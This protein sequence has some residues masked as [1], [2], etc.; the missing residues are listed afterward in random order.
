MA[1]KLP[2]KDLPFKF[3]A[4]RS[5]KPQ[6]DTVAEACSSAG[7]LLASAARSLEQVRIETPDTQAPLKVIYI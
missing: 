7:N 6:I 5:L 3:T 4:R 2:A 1:T